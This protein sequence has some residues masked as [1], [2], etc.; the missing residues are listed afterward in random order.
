M[1][2]LLTLL[3]LM[4]GTAALA[5]T[6]P[7]AP[8]TPAPAPVAK[9]VVVHRR[10]HVRTVTHRPSKNGVSHTNVIKSRT[11]KTPQGVATHTVKSTTTTPPS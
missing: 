4:A 1:K 11:V 10:T 2:P 9:K 6:P 3:A 5:Q 8:V 7:P